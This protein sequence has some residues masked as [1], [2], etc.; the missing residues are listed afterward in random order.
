M[1]RS[2]CG[3]ALSRSM[4]RLIFRAVMAQRRS[5]RVAARGSCD[6]GRARGGGEWE[7]SRS[8]LRLEDVAVLV[9]EIH[10]PVVVHVVDVRE[11][12]RFLHV[13]VDGVTGFVF[14]DEVTN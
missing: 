5:W 1:N 14:V 12:I 2:S 7:G 10:V 4:M 6:R 8:Y 13:L 3:A 9:E 11:E